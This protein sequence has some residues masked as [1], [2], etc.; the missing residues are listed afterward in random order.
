MDKKRSSCPAAYRSSP[1]RTLAPP[2]RGTHRTHPYPDL[3]RKR[4]E[5]RSLPG[6]TPKDRAECG[7]DEAEGPVGG[8]GGGVVTQDVIPPFVT[9]IDTRAKIR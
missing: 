1:L 7:M 8:E 3:S 5:E 6:S 9:D 2:Y 4:R